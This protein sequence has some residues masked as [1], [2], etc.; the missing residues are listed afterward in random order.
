MLSSCRGRVWGESLF[1]P[2]LAGPFLSLTQFIG[3]LLARL[4]GCAP[5]PFGLRRR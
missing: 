1:A 5:P 3:F 2:G 4:V